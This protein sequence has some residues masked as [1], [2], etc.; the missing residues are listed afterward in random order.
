MEQSICGI[1]DH[2][3][4]GLHCMWIVPH[5][6]ASFDAIDDYR[7]WRVDPLKRGVVLLKKSTKAH[8]HMDSLSILAHIFKCHVFQ[9]TWDETQHSK[10]LDLVPRGM[11]VPYSAAVNLT[12]GLGISQVIFSDGYDA[13]RKDGEVQGIITY[14]LR[15]RA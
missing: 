14:Y 10:L 9:M 15:D 13:F 1:M 7:L 6:K 8:T 4:R 11:L 3:T 2:S 5:N 12:E